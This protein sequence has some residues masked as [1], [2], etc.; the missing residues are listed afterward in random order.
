MS[1]IKL[2]EEAGVYIPGEWATQDKIKTGEALA[3][4]RGIMAG[5]EQ[6][7]EI[8]NKEYFDGRITMHYMQQDV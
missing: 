7:L 8:I 5:R 4:T 3:Y 2:I 6:A 1:L